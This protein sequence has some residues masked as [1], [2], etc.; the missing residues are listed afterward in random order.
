MLAAGTHGRGAYT[1]TNRSA[2]PALVVS[3]TDSGLPVGPG[4]N[5]DY[6]ITVKNIGNAAGDRCL[7]QRADPGQ[8]HVLVCRRKA[9]TY[10]GGKVRWDG[11]DRSGRRTGQRHVQRPD[12]AEAQ[13]SVTPS[14][15]TASWSA[16]PREW[17]PP[18]ARMPRP[19]AASQRGQHHAGPQTGGAKVGTSRQ[20]R[21]DLTNT[22]YT[23]D[24][25]NIVQHRRLARERL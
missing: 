7:C 15:M 20:L 4:S 16:P 11:L 5:I 8:H 14:S 9:A 25:Y 2:R 18:A 12:L 22:G 24:S 17:T 3:K 6:T 10:G 21:R 19:I 13:T 1:L 23:A